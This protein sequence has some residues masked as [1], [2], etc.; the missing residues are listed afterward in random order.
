ME[1][2]SVSV[3][4]GGSSAFTATASTSG[5]VTTV[6]VA[7]AYG[8]NYNPA[9]VRVTMTYD[10]MTYTADCAITAADTAKYLGEGST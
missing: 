3:S 1:A 5:L 10:G 6:T 4:N 7:A 2:A 9:T 8:N